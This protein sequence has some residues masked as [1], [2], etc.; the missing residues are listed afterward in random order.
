M[1][2]L[3]RNLKL[4]YRSITSLK[5]YARNPRTHSPRQI[6]QIAESIKRFGF[7]NPILVDADGGVIA[8][9]GRIEAAK[10]LGIERVPTIRLDRMT[11]AEKRAY[12]VADNKLAENAGWDRALLALELQY[13]AELDIDFD[14]TVIGFDT[15][16]I[17]LL[18]QDDDE[19]RRYDL[20]DQ[21][22]DPGE[23]GPPVTRAGDLWILGGHRL[24]CADATRPESFNR[25]LGPDLAQMVII[26]PPF[27]VAIDGHVCG[28][29]AIRHREFPMA[30]G[31][32]SEAEFTAFLKT[33][34]DHLAAF[35]IDGSIHFVFMDWRHAF[36]LLA[37]ARPTY[38]EFKNLCVWAK[39]NAGM[40]SLYRSRHELIF[41]FKRALRPMSI[42]WR[43]GAT[44]ALAPTCGSTPE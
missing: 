22:P 16:E 36:E 20:A 30:A 5:S 18:I 13:V 8:G 3:L 23:S 17:D 31:E 42:T 21:I 35:S 37:A 39:D 11:E 29:G 44:A 34:F 15:A 6:H 24:L 32:M 7:T 4:E 33:T 40:G 43:W 14:L 25:L 38:S 27:N 2:E 9:H 12:I 26:D 41:V 10:L 28:R 19:S 1:T